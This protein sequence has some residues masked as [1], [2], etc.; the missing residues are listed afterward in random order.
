[1]RSPTFYDFA[2]IDK[3]LA[4]GAENPKLSHSTIKEEKSKPDFLYYYYVQE[5][6]MT[7]HLKN[8]R[9]W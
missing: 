6:I 8:A 7:P 4:F 5:V 3:N 1:M 9:C 2:G